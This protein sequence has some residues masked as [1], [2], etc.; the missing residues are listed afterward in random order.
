MHG[1]LPRGTHLFLSFSIATFLFWCAVINANQLIQR[2]EFIW[3][4]TVL[5]VF[6]PYKP[7]VSNLRNLGKPWLLKKKTS[8]LGFFFLENKKVAVIIIIIIIEAE[9][10]SIK[11]LF[12]IFLP[13]EDSHQFL[14]LS[15]NHSHVE[16]SY[17]VTCHWQTTG[18]FLFVRLFL[19]FI[20]LLFFYYFFSN[21]WFLKPG[22]KFRF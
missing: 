17:S 7:C 13:W 19:F 5:S 12:H 22:C 6:R 1:L 21:R 15:A 9:T 11:E 4:F 18:D 2:V 20:L 10:N 8:C 14:S 3:L 16:S